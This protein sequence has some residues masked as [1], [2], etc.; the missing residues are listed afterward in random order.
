MLIGSVC[1]PLLSD[2]CALF[3]VYEIRLRLLDPTVH[4]ST[5]DRNVLFYLILQPLK[6][7]VGTSGLF[8]IVLLKADFFA[9]NA[10]QLS[11]FLKAN[12]SLAIY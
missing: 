11:L 9:F 8:K 4:F 7:L 2:K 10:R 6:L 12:S 5:N 3:F 1:K